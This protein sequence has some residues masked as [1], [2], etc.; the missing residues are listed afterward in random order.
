LQPAIHQIADAPH[1]I[2]C[3][4]EAQLVKQ[5]LQRVVT[6]LDVADCVS[7]HGLKQDPLGGELALEVR[8]DVP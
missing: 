3:R 5:A 4:I 7:S 8:D 2:V 1:R 6:A